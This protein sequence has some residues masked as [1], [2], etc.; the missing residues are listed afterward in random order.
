M[1]VHPFRNEEGLDQHVVGELQYDERKNDLERQRHVPRIEQRHRNGREGACNRA[2]I[3]DQI[4]ESREHADE[5]K[6]L[7]PQKPEGDRRQNPE[8]HGIRELAPEVIPQ[9]DVHLV[10]EVEGKL[11]IP[12]RHDANEHLFH[13]ATVFKEKEDEE[14]DRHGIKDDRKPFVEYEIHY[15]I[16]QVC[17]ELL[18]FFLQIDFPQPDEPELRANDG[19]KAENHLRGLP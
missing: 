15:R 17:A 11:E 12:V 13:L 10:Q 1:K 5:K 16:A 7:H 3:R 2:D 9:L 4:R 14:G 8:R 18:D 6:V 19:L